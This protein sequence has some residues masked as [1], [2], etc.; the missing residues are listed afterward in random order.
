[1][2]RET[3][4]P[5]MGDTLPVAEEEVRFPFEL[6]PQGEQGGNLPEREKPGYIWKDAGP[7][8]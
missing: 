4:A 2:A 1:M 3:Q 6:F 8:W 5:G 7:R